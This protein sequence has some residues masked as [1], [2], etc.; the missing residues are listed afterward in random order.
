MEI[1]SNKECA[2]HYTILIDIL[3]NQTRLEGL[4]ETGAKKKG[5]WVAAGEPQYKC[6]RDSWMRT[7]VN[8]NHNLG[9]SLLTSLT[10][11]Q[12]AGSDTLGGGHCLW[13]QLQ[14]SC[15]SIC[16]SICVYSDLDVTV[17][18]LS[19]LSGSSHW[20]APVCSLFF[21]FYLLP[22]LYGTHMPIWARH[23]VSHFQS[24]FVS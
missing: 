7:E 18:Y 5:K 16:I 15:C 24:T 20:A 4:K 1:S 2:L 19:S 6:T 21:F 13:P 17:V 12:E 3:I 10:A 14:P 9:D 23:H 8:I 11:S 22:F